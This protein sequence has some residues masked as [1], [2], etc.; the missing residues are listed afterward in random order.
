M[1]DEEQKM[2]RKQE[3]EKARIRAVLDAEVA[4]KERK[5]M[6]TEM[7]MQVSL[8]LVFEVLCNQTYPVIHTKSQPLNLSGQTKAIFGENGKNPKIGRNPGDYQRS[9]GFQGREE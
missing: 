8:A 9:Q 1:D 3:E 2:K 7:A 4:E 5:K 6:E